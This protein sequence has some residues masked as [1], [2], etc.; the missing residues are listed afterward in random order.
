MANDH[1]SLLLALLISLSPVSSLPLILQ[2]W[3]RCSQ[4]ILIP[5]IN[6]AGTN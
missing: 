6:D 4:N 3:V 5:N 1:G 2:V